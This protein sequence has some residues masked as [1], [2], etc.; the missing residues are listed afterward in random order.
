MWLA[1]HFS[2]VS[3]NDSPKCDPSYRTPSW[4]DDENDYADCDDGFRVHCH[5]IHYLGSDR[6]F[7][8]KSPVLALP[9]GQGFQLQ[10]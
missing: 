8:S 6:C 3:S 10:W 2:S 9:S 1:R 4:C 5:S 7:H